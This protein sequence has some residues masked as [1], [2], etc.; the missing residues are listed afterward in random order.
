[1]TQH[2]D[3]A[4]ICMPSV[5]FYMLLILLH[6]NSGSSSNIGLLAKLV[7]IALNVSCCSML[8]GWSLT[9]WALDEA[10]LS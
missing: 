7:P 6:I 3:M 10:A 1:M 9:V 4:A 5:Q 8:L 2:L